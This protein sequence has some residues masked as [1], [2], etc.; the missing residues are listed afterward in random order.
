MKIITLPLTDS[1]FITL[2]NGGKNSIYSLP[3]SLNGTVVRDYNAVETDFQRQSFP[4]H[5]MFGTLA[6]MKEQDAKNIMESAGLVAPYIDYCCRA[7]PCNNAL[8]SL[9]S[10]IGSNN[11]EY[12]IEDTWLIIPNPSKKLK[13]KII[14]MEFNVGR[15]DFGYGEDS[16]MDLDVFMSPI[17]RLSKSVTFSVRIPTFLYNKCLTDA[18]IEN[19]PKHD[20]IECSTISGLHTEM[21]ELVSL[22]HNIWEI[23]KNA[24]QAKKVICINFASSERTTRDDLNF[25]YT[26]QKIST[27]FNFFVAFQMQSNLLSSKK[28]LF[29]YKKYQTGVGST[30]K[31]IKGIIDSELQGGRNWIGNTPSVIIDWTQKREDFLTLLEENFRKLSENLNEFLKDLDADKIEMLIQNKELL[32]LTK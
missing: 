10:F 24:S 1:F 32:K 6:K 17:T 21:G 18:D 23:E 28:K 25:G 13:G 31:G 30:E 14:P 9:M 27:T 4:D 11:W 12:F 2:F 16:K 22:A 20:Y 7:L 26:G 29:T 3:K 15:M 5:K 19:R 8:D